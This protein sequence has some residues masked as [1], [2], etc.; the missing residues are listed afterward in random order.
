MKKIKVE[1]IDIIVTGKPDKPYYEIRYR[2]AGKKYYN[3]GYSSYYIH[4]VFNWKDK[5]FQL[6][7]PKKNIFRK[8]FD[9]V[10]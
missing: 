8:L 10:R 7:E 9:S 3:I 6:V 4:N 2:E 5:C 1:E